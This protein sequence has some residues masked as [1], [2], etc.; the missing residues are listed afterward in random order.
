MAH[1]A[2]DLQARGVRKRGLLTGTMV[3]LSLAGYVDDLTNLL[4]LPKERATT[5]ASR[6]IKLD[7]D[8]DETLSR[9]E[10]KMIT[11]MRGADLIVFRIN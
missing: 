4:T 8:L 7:A 1:A 3:D 10:A 5:L 11:E 9:T 6:L 2:W